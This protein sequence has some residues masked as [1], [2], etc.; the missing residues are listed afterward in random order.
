MRLC[1]DEDKMRGEEL[2]ELR[3]SRRIANGENSMN[4]AFSS[5]ME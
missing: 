2:G 3:A 1:H 5:T 4:I